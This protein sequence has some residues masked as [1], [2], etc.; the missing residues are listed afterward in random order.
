[1]WKDPIVDEIHSV[2][3]KISGECNYDLKQIVERLRKKE[4]THKDRLVSV[5]PG[6]TTASGIES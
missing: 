5:P 4:R 1:M 6:K 2:R 3:K